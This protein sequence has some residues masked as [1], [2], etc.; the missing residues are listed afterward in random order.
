MRRWSAPLLLCAVATTGWVE[1][2]GLLLSPPGLR[3]SSISGDVSP[4]TTA[5]PRTALSGTSTGHRHRA[6]ALRKHDGRRLRRGQGVTATATAAGGGCFAAT[7]VDPCRFRTRGFAP[8]AAAAAAGPGRSGPQHQ[9]SRRPSL[10]VASVSSPGDPEEGLEDGGEAVDGG[11]GS[12]S[13][14]SPAGV[15]A[16][17]DFFGDD[18]AP[19]VAGG[20]FSPEESGES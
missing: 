1:T 7:G 14:G 20:D 4:P 8:A 12:Q 9:R 10:A 17:G 19:T 13:A 18:T 15:E 6:A 5:A 16:A 3:S 2:L 11:A